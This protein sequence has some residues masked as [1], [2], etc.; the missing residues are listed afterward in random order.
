MQVRGILVNDSEKKSKIPY[1]LLKNICLSLTGL[2]L[3]AYFPKSK[4][5]L[6]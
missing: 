4:A 6:G 2:S 1:I 5:L 3:R